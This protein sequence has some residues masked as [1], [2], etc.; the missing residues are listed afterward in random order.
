[1]VNHS[2]RLTREFKRSRIKLNEELI[3]SPQTYQDELFYHI[4]IP[5]TSKFF[6]IGYAEYVFI[7]L[8]DGATSF[9]HALAVTAQKLG[10]KA[11]TE[12]QATQTTHW[13]LENGLAHDV[14]QPW[15]Q[16]EAKAASESTS[17]LQK[18]N[19]FWIKIPLGRPHAWL[20]RIQPY[21]G[22][23][24][25]PAVVT[26]SV[27]WMIIALVT[28]AIHWN[29]FLAS[30]AVIFARSN[31]IWM[32]LTWIVLKIVH[33]LAHGLVCHRFGG[34]VKETGII[35]ILLAPLAYVDVTS[36][37]RFSSRWQ[38][39]AVA[40]AGMYVELLLAAICVTLWCG[41]TSEWLAYHLFNVIFMA[42][43]STLLFNANPLM[44]FDGYFVLSDLLKVPN[45]YAAGSQSFW[46]GVR[47]LF[48][49]QRVT[50]LVL[51]ASSES[52]RGHHLWILCGPLESRHLH[53][54]GHHGI[55][56]VRRAGHI[57]CHVG[58]CLLAHSTIDCVF[59]VIGNTASVNDLIH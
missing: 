20:E 2:D 45:L 6:R 37:W 10:P 23:L 48:Y 27:G 38:R 29:A 9:A 33:E 57:D 47:W 43:V 8:L 53:R 31:W 55:R 54:I 28:V 39:I 21:L 24:F 3:F 17:L 13:L 19:P 35:F 15:S 7:S 56:D 16:D 25:H 14:E 52:K 5:S 40:S 18:L 1:M 58:S 4:E 42:S 11:L 50:G 36:S 26:L 49:G 22:W 32:L 30:S 44:R 12:K 34:T 46:N 51:R 41:T 59:F